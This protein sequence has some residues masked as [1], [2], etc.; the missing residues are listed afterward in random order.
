[1]GRVG[2]LTLT[3]EPQSLFAGAELLR[4]S[5]SVMV[6]MESVSSNQL[7][8]RV[9]YRRSRAAEAAWPLWEL[10]AL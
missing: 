3:A 5:L 10:L 7:L 8:K 1:M 6:L 2:R 9:S 4:S